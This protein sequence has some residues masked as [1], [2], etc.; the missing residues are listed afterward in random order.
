[1]RPGEEDDDAEYMMAAADRDCDDQLSNILYRTGGYLS[2][3]ASRVVPIT[4]SG[5]SGSPPG[6]ESQQQRQPSLTADEDK[7]ILQGSSTESVLKQ[8][9][10]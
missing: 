2:V 6:T 4:E 1:M 9:N 7:L 8:S 10:D 5:L 3:V